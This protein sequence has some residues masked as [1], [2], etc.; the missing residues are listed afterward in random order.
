[1]LPPFKRF[2]HIICKGHPAQVAG[3]VVCSVPVDVVNGVASFRVWVFAKRLG[4]DTADKE[5]AGLSVF[6]QCHAGIT[7]V[8]DEVPQYPGVGM[9]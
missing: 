8:I 2:F 9:F 4:H 3:P 5:M 6:A 1:M 7:L